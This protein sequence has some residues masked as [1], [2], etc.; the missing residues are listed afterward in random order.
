MGTPEFAV[1]TLQE[2]INST[3]HDVVAIFTQTP[4]AAGRGMK[5]T[6]SPVYKLAISSNIP[7]YIPKT[8]KDEKTAK[9]IDSIDADIIVVVAYGFIIPADILAA[10]KYGCLNIHP[11]K[12]PKY[13]GAAPLQRT[14]INGEK[15]TAICVMQMDTGLDTGDILLQKNLLLNP[16]I[17]LQKLHDQCAK[18]GGKLL[19]EVLDNIEILPRIKQ[20]KEGVSYAHKLSRKEGKVNWQETAFEIDCKIRGMNPWP[21]VYFEHEGKI[22]KILS[23]EY[24][25][26]EHQANPGELLNENFEVACGSGTLMIKYLKPEG[27]AKMLATD[28]LRGIPAKTQ[29]IIFS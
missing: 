1:P 26:N 17:T 21:G 22:I 29:T 5:L 8:L 24:T 25:K 19:I 12:L 16:R 14:I 28:Y 3:K 18:T 10:K 13:R 15:E 11:S 4:K 2:L 9:L 20:S 7:V 23:A 6:G 27:R